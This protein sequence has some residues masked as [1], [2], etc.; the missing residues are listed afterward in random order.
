MQA[1]SQLLLQQA[2]CLQRTHFLRG[3][4][5]LLKT[6]RH[7]LHKQ[8]RC[9]QLCLSVSSK[10]GHGKPKLVGMGGCGLDMLAQVATFP[11]PDT[12]SRTE[13]METQGGGNAGNALTSAARLGLSRPALITKIGSDSVGD[14]ILAELEG[15]GV[16]VSHVLRAPNAPSPFTYIIVDRE[17][18]TRT[19]IHTPGEPL[20]QEEMTEE[21]V[22]AALAGATLIY[23][24]GRLTE[25][26]LVVARAAKAKGIKVLVEAERLRPNLEALLAEADYVFTSAKYPQECTGESCLADAL[27]GLMGALPKAEWVLTTLGKRGSVLLQRE[28]QPADGCR[29]AE[30]QA[31]L[32]ELLTAA[33]AEAE[34]HEQPGCTS[35]SGVHIRAGAVKSSEGP[36][37]LLCTTPAEGQNAA[38][39]ELAKASAAAAAASANADSSNAAAYSRQEASSPRQPATSFCATVTVSTA[40]SLPSDAVQDT[41]G[42]GDAYLGAIL[43]S[44]STG[45]K[46]EKAMRLAAVVAACKCTALGSRPGLP[47]HV[48]IHDQLLR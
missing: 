24:D 43:H 33:Q 23:F 4:L 38:A 25:A 18:G 22:E 12:K 11:E 17:G 10:A 7:G 48:D 47:R 14:Q 28:A 26:A 34:S 29:E 46:L 1:Y 27:I 30:L 16:D 45:L 42:A 8:Q 2:D 20:S 15:D 9:R 35:K 41:T 3:S 31:V 5:Q 21:K 36:L 32:D 19:C 40:A 13:Q 6:A 37:T 44:L 39:M